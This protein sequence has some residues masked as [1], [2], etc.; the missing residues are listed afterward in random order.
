MIRSALC[1]SACFVAAFAAFGDDKS[2]EKKKKDASEEKQSGPVIW[3]AV[4]EPKSVKPGGE[5]T[6]KLTAKIET[7]WHI[8]AVDK[9]TGLSKK[10][11]L[12]L[13][14]A[15]KLTADK[16]WKIPK[17]TKDEKAEEE[18]HYYEGD[19]TFTRKIKANDSAEGVL[20]ATATVEFMACNEDMC[21]PPKKAVVK[22]ALKVQK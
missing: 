14:L 16:D 15:D 10:T 20:E 19:T 5:A 2:D 12:K 18:T 1:V 17:P 3:S 11:S 21:L 22:A 6:L 13:A 8:Y 4:F 7:G 9:P